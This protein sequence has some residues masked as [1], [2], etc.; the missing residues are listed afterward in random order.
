M[1]I[2][3]VILGFTFLVEAVFG[4]GGAFIAVPLL[5][6]FMHPKDAILLV[7]LFQALKVVLLVPVWRLVDVKTL[8]WMPI[9]IVAGTMFGA[10]VLDSLDADLLR[11]MLAGYLVFYVATDYLKWNF[12][13]TGKVSSLTA[14]ASGGAISGV[15]GMG[16]P[17]IVTYLKSCQMP[18][19]AFRA[20][21]LAALMIANFSRLGMEIGD[22]WHSDVVRHYFLPTLAVFAVAMYAGSQLPKFIPDHVFKHAINVILILSAAMLFYKSMAA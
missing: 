17:A 4:F 7:L 9:G 12:M 6:L 5:S 18:K 19:E 8:S 15:I 20:T 14:G 1:V 10:L 11:L 21:L 2:E 16:G 22:I 13:T 3:L